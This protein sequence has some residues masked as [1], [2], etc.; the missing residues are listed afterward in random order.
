[1]NFCNMLENQ[2]IIIYCFTSLVGGRQVLAAGGDGEGAGRT[3]GR[4]RD[5]RPPAVGAGAATM[6]HHRQGGR[7]GRPLPL[8]RRRPK[9]AP[10]GGSDWAKGNVFII[11]LSGVKCGRKCFGKILKKKFIKGS[12]MRPRT[13]RNPFFSNCFITH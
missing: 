2:G 10:E 13:R 11:L 3:E 7:H 5:Q 9:P 1:M 6:R 4:A 8:E 12:T